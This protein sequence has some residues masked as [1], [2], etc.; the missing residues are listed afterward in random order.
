VRYEIETAVTDVEEA[1]KGDNVE[2]IT[3]KTSVMMEASHKVAEQMYQQE[4]P[5][6]T[7]DVVDAE[8]EDA[9]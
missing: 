4:Q 9:K 5:Q 7:E 6:E 8:F 3:S 1:I 2:N